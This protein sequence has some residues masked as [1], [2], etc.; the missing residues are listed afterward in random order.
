MTTVF[1][2]SCFVLDYFVELFYGLYF[3]CF[4]V[5]VVIWLL[6]PLFVVVMVF[7][8]LLIVE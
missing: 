8:I 5:I 2:A 1:V 4:C 6:L 7:V 3:A